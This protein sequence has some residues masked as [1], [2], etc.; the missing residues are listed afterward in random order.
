[1]KLSLR[2]ETIDGNLNMRYFASIEDYGLAREVSGDTC[3]DAARR[4][5]SELRSTAEQ[6]ERDFARI[7]KRNG[8]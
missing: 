3:E 6:A 2:S 5:I 4:L 1:M 7:L 8:R